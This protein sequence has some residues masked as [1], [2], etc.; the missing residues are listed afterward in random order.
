M[1]KTLGLILTSVFLLSTLGIITGFVMPA[2]ASNGNDA[3]IYTLPYTPSVFNTSNININMFFNVTSNATVAAN[4]NAFSYG[5]AVNATAN[6]VIFEVVFPNTTTYSTTLSL[7]ELGLNKYFYYDPHYNSVFVVLNTTGSYQ[8]PAAGQELVYSYET[9]TGISSSQAKYN[10]TNYLN[11]SIPVNQYITLLSLPYLIHEVDTKYP[12]NNNNLEKLPSG[13]E[14]EFIYAGYTYTITIAAQ[15]KLTGTLTNP[16]YFANSKAIP[17]S[18]YAVG[19]S[20]ITVAVYDQYLIASSTGMF[21]FTLTYSS[22]APAII[23]WFVIFSTTPTP[24]PNTIPAPSANFQAPKFS[25]YNT[26]ND[27]LVYTTSS[28]PS[29]LLFNG[30]L[31]VT[32]NENVKLTQQTGTY[33]YTS[34]NFN[35]TPP[36]NY[37]FSGRLVVLFNGFIYQNGSATLTAN[38]FNGSIFFFFPSAPGPDSYEESQFVFYVSPILPINTTTNIMSPNSVEAIYNGMSIWV[39]FPQIVIKYE[40]KAYYYNE[41]VQNN[42]VYQLKGKVIETELNAAQQFSYGNT[43]KEPSFSNS[44]SSASSIVTYTN[45]G[46]ATTNI[47]GTSLNFN[48]V[49]PM[50]FE[51]DSLGYIYLV[52]FH[53]WGP[54]TTVTVSGQDPKGV[55]V[56]LGSFRAY[57]ALPSFYT[58]PK[59]PIAGL[60]CDNMYTLAQLSD[61]GSVLETST[62]NS[63]ANNQTVIGP[64]DLMSNA[65][66]HVAIYNGTKLV[67]SELL[68]LLPNE[69]TA[70]ITTTVTLNGQTVA[71]TYPSAPIAIYPVDLKF[72]PGFSYGVTT[73]VIYNTTIPTYVVTVYMPLNY[74]LHTKIVMWYVSPDYAAFYYYSSTGQYQTNNVTLTFANVTPELVMPQ[75]F[76]VGKLYMPFGIYDP[77]YVFFSSISVGPQSGVLEAVENGFN[78]GNITAITVELNGMNESV[79][80]SPSNVSKLLISTNLGEV[81]QCSPLFETTLF[82]ISALASLLGLPNPAALNGS[83]LY[84]TYHDVISGAY[85]TNKTLLIV[86]QFYVMSP[87]TPGSVEWILTAKYINATTGI[88]VEISYAVVQ[89]PSAK[90]VDINAANA[91]ITQIQVTGVKIVSK[92]ANVTIMYNPSNSSTIVYMNG[93]FV[94]SYGGNLISTLSQTSTFGVYYGPV[95]NLYVATSSLSSPNGTMYIVLGSH[96]VAVGT[97]NLYTYTGYHFGPYTALPLTSNVTFTV[98][99]PVTHATVSGQTT[100]GAF[101]NTP[102]RLSPLGV[103]IPQTAQNKVFYYYSTPLVL[104]PT[105]QYIVLSVT[106]V[107]SYSYP[108]YIET[109]S[110]LGSNVTTGTPVPGTPAFQT[111]YSPSLGP[112]VVL[113]VPVQSY[114][115]IS[116]SS[117]SEPHTV[118]MFAV[119]FAGGPAISLYPTFLVYTNVTAV[120]S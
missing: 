19:R 73:N 108:F 60:T 48:V 117:P 85:V 63:N 11:E 71:L 33:I 24:N 10:I 97:A 95:V 30:Q 105:S 7:G 20:N 84:V 114:Q 27:S 50:K 77:Y 89:Q 79:V 74:I 37:Y 103:S 112:G 14:L 47:F 13:T 104:S 68:G 39:G 32:A 15:V 109:V 115:F 25:I 23:Y 16:L 18:A 94:T 72:E 118:V 29:V 106:S 34:S 78:I 120:S 64:Y 66:L 83:Y 38:I 113:Q 92:Y 61:V 56:S 69:T 45:Y 76:P 43:Y 111:V 96:K 58:L 54:S 101:N 75:M 99:D 4:V 107:I 119:P 91:S 57:I 62:A 31:N 49:M 100:L 52:T 40:I 53:I 35:V 17:G 2:Q 28:K 26:K 90:V 51:V 36:G 41:T 98:Q 6:D 93:K 44:L 5:A 46:E 102:I 1:N 22:Q 86:G 88:P 59:T 3:A 12:Y 80:L 82:N 55:S 42:Y 116:L 110:F 67:K 65:G 9:S 81:A 8:S 70:P 21:D 87:T